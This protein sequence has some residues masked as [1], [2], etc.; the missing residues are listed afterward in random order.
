MPSKRRSLSKAN[1]FLVRAFASIG[2]CIAGYLLTIKLTGKISSIVG[3]GSEGCFE[4][5]AGLL[6]LRREAGC[7]VLVQ[8]YLKVVSQPTND[9]DYKSARQHA[10]HAGRRLTPA[11]HSRLRRPVHHSRTS[12]RLR[13]ANR[14]A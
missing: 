7:V 14:H 11:D 4:P 8:V 1:F 12:P 6:A 2:L 13:H 9:S 10:L 3:C 5:A